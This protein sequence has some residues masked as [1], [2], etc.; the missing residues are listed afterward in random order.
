MESSNKIPKGQLDIDH[1]LDKDFTTLT[2]ATTPLAGTEE[3]A[4]VQSGE[5]KKVAVSEVGGSLRTDKYLF[6]SQH[7][8]N[9]STDWYSYRANYG[10]SIYTTPLLTGLYDGTTNIITSCRVWSQSVLFNQK[11][12]KITIS[13]EWIS[14][15]TTLRFQYFKIAGS[16]TSFDNA[17]IHEVTLPSNNG[18]RNKT[19]EVPV[20][21]TMEEGGELTIAFFND[22]LAL[23]TRT[24]TITVEVEE[25]I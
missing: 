25:V 2:S 9:A 24:M 15:P 8:A 21:F 17:T 20:P 16:N 12:T 3:I 1:K 10:E 6:F 7:I 11:V 18:A 23:Q 5:T 4:I 22:N 14:N 19:Y 13:S